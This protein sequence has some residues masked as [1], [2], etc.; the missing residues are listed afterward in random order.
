MDYLT[1]VFAAFG[2][3]STGF[4]AAMA[5]I[6]HFGEEKDDDDHHIRVKVEVEVELPP[7]ECC[8]NQPKKEVT[9]MKN[10]QDEMILNRVENLEAALMEKDVQIRK[11]EKKPIE[12]N[13][14][15]ELILSRVENL[16]A[17]LMEKD[18]QI[19][20]LEKKPIE[21]FDQDETILNRVENLEAALMEKD[22]QIRKLEKEVGSMNKQP[23][24]IQKPLPMLPNSAY[25]DI[26][27]VAK[28]G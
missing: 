5:V 1:K 10:K 11:L 7:S 2:L 16:E 17:A 3:M 20:K 24:A 4:I 27:D 9:K 22:V 28:S 15:D 14:Q 8:P 19:R 12:K 25:P 26:L 13:E 23:D 6:A 21:K 18:V